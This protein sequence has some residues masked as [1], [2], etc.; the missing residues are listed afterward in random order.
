MRAQVMSPA[1]KEPPHPSPLPQEREECSAPSSSCE[2]DR[3]EKT[4]DWKLGF[5]VWRSPLLRERE[6]QN[7]VNRYF[8]RSVKTQ[9]IAYC[10]DH[11]F[12]EKETELSG[13]R[14]GIGTE[15]V[16]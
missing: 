4:V 11:S 13:L 15:P 14:F 10:V 3:V 5:L 7:S 12:C 1:T 2:R 8:L 9:G 6:H 16:K